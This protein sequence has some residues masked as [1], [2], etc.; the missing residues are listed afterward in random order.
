[1]VTLGIIGCGYWG[2]N[3]VR[4]FNGIPGAR[5]KTVSDLRVGRLDSIRESYPELNTTT[6][7]QSVIDDEEINAI[8][9]ATPVDTHHRLGEQVL[10]AGK[11]LFV[12]KPLA[13]TSADAWALVELA[14]SVGR[15]LVV[16]HVFQFAPGV[17]RIK[18]EIEKGILGKVFHISS[19]RINLGPPDP[20][21][22]VIWDLAPHDCSII[23]HLLGETPV[24]VM[25]RGDS[26]KRNGV[27]DNAHIE[28]VFP[29]GA[30]AHIHVSWLSANKMRL[31]QLFGERGSIT[32]DEMLAL[33]G[34]VKRYDNGIDN[35]VNVSDA[36]TVQLGYSTGDIHVLQLEQHEPLR[37]ECADFI[38][39][40]NT[41]SNP[42]N[43]GVMGARVV[44][45][46][47][48]ISRVA[49][50]QPFEHKTNGAERKVKV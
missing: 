14:R 12:E 49:I 27:I 15:V 2:P 10:R 25:A 32:Y 11:H 6:D 22:D 8:V 34:K 37:M 41:G 1:V 5:V 47:E 29:S 40:I 48:T 18:H 19:T 44:E 3:L 33:D 4:N 28:L 36:D 45:L 24:G 43:D 16:G 39:A 23:L 9:L 35:R 21:L 17:R 26:Y 38:R 31:L 42:V 20:T 46:L 50:C 13:Q 30:T 7:Y